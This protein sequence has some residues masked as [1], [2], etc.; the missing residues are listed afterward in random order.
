MA[1]YCIINKVTHFIIGGDL[2]T[3]LG[4]FH[5]SHTIALNLFLIN[6]CLPLCMCMWCQLIMSL[7]VHVIPVF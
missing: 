4:R 1:N 2:G 7:L 5:S 3:Y 6:E